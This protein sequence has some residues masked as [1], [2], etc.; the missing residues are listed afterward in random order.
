MM[1]LAALLTYLLFIPKA[2]I[3]DSTNGSETQIHTGSLWNPLPNGGS[4]ESH[5]NGDGVL[6][7]Q[8]K[9][10]DPIVIE[11]EIEFP[12]GWTPVHYDILLE[13]HIENATST[14]NVNIWM[15]RDEKV[16]ELKPIILDITDIEITDCKLFSRDKA[17]IEQFLDYTCEY[18]NKNESYVINVKETKFMPT[19]VSVQL[20]FTNK[21]GG[22]LTGFYKGSFINEETKEPST[23]VS[24]QFSPIDARRAF[25]ALDR[26]YA[27]AT[28][29]ISLIRPT[30]KRISIS[31]MPVE[32][33]ENVRDGFIRENFQVTPKMS[34][35]LVAFHISDLKLGMESDDNDKSLPKIRMYA[36]PEYENMTNFSYQLTA[37]SLPFFEEYFDIKFRLPKID[38]VAVPDFGFS[39][40]ENWGLITF[41][42]SAL[43]V[44]EDKK[45]S[46]VSQLHRVAKTLVHEVAHQWF[47][48][49]V[50]MEWYDDLWLKEGF[51][52]YLHYVATDSIKSEWDYFKTITIA[53]F[54]L[55]M[56]KDCDSSSRPI[57]FKVRTKSD[58]RRVFDPISYSKGALIINM[59][60]G[61]LGEDTF[62]LGLQNYLKKFEYGNAIQ[63][64][65]W[66]AM[67]INARKQKVLEDNYSVKEIMDS[68]TVDSAGFP[69]VT[70]SRNDTDII[71]TQQRYYLPYINDSDTTKWFIP[72]SYASSRRPVGSEIPEHWMSNKHDQLVIEN[73]VG[74]NEWFL[75]NVN[76]TGYYRVNYDKLSWKNLIQN[77]MK[78]SDITRAQLI[79]DSFA[80]ARANL[81]GYDIPITFGLIL[82]TA[83]YEY[84]PFWAFANGLEYVTNMIKRETAFENYRRVIRYILRT[85]YD[86]I[87]FEEQPGDSDIDLLHRARIVNLAC[88]FGID[89]CTVA[90]QLKF[91]EWIADKANNK[92]PPN[93]KSTIYCITLREGGEQ[94]WN[95]ALKRFEDSI[96]ASE[97]EVILDALGCTQKTW[98]LSKYLN[99]T[100]SPTSPIRKQDGA[101]AFQA[102]A[103][104][105]AGAEI[106]YDFLYTNIAEI[107]EYFGDGFST[108]SKMVDAVTI[109]M[110]KD[111]HKE[112]FQRFAE[113][114]N[115]LGLVAIEKSIKLAEIEID[116]NIYW[117][118]NIYNQLKDTLDKAVADLRLVN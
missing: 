64:D 89:R 92:I 34:T 118:N 93:L 100:V 17:D 52:T 12:D 45:S 68:W 20:N 94:E 1:I 80:L 27:K 101:R 88:E 2:C 46:S 30:N 23:F 22:T 75:V 16:K 9:N 98:L 109:F 113:K 25:P 4:D 115:K 57:S 44:P 79:D 61:F 81:T 26:P 43:L 48:N 41:R 54:A 24:T 56:P 29:K 47:G 107:A 50:T 51:S 99:M 117:R 65:L 40:M 66:E 104:N 31:N 69:V 106:A 78:F 105:I 3:T 14:G 111:Y 91:R 82:R 71:L 36:Q 114:A 116:K 62:R 96:N 32:S 102:V 77:S 60:R 76:R 63:D 59:M 55:A 83:P 11:D 74:E 110:N 35:Y 67:T 108:I 38:M 39:G 103:R 97:K 42:E 53:E 85:V 37:A 6:S 15:I 112:N 8:A 28:F 90:A 49:L 58:I 21:L 19:N 7:D 10:D 73:I 84:L 18:G 86:E 33:T 72:I 13:P 70:V 5:T 95:F 87:G